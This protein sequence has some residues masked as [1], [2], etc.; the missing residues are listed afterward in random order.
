MEQALRTYWRARMAFLGTVAAIF[1]LFFLWIMGRQL[2]VGEW[3]SAI[4]AG[5]I[6]A[7][8]GWLATRWWRRYRLAGAPPPETDQA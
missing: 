7:L 1:A 8:L 2:W 5:A 3:T 4:F 6:A